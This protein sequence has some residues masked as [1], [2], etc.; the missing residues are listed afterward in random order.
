LSIIGLVLSAL[1]LLL[2]YQRIFSGPLNQHLRLMP[3]LDRRE[4]GVLVPLLVLL[5]VF[6][7]YPLPLMRLA[8]DAA[9]AMV[10]IFGGA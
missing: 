6:G 9:L 3:D 7:V 2:M 1:A 10:R 8:N 5:I 4:W